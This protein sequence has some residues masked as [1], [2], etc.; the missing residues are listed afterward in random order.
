MWALGR[1]QPS[2]LPLSTPLLEALTDAWEEDN[3]LFIEYDKQKKA[4]SAKVRVRVR[5]S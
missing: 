2:P 1:P 3:G 4:D 5:V